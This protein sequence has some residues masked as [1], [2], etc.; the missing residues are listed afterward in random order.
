MN[1]NCYLLFGNDFISIKK[2]T[3]YIFKANEIQPENVENY[4][5]EEEGISNA[6]T[7]AS[8]MPFL[9]EKRGVV[10]RNADFLTEGKSSNVSTEEI[11][12]LIRYCEID[13]PST[14]L[15]IQVQSAKLD[16]RKKIV[17]YLTK[18]LI[19]KDLNVD[20]KSD[21]IFDF[22]RDELRKSSLSI[23][24]LALTQFVSRVGYNKTMIANELDKLISYAYGKDMITAEM[25]FD[26]TTRNID[27]NI[28]QLVNA[29]LDNNKETMLEIYRDLMSIK[30]DAVWMLGAISS[31][32]QE[33]LYTKGLIKEKYKYEDVMKYF[34]ATKG[35]TY[36]IMKNAK[37]AEGQKLLGYLSQLEELDYKIKS[38]QIDKNLALEL[39]LLGIE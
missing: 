36:Y 29:V 20:L 15:V 28:F 3:E 9:V 37:E 1:Q 34:Q 14:V 6:I 17:K 10:I 22:I 26:V 8:T 23:D 12:E 2:E 31:K 39:F 18:H 35:R 25:I 21:T 11:N 38:G 30:V 4:D 19:V 27:D 24:P 33:I 7:S 13:N 16:S 5:A 32:F